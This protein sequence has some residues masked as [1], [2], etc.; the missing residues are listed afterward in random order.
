MPISRRNVISAL[1]ASAIPL[2]LRA[3]AP[4][5]IRDPRI[6]SLAI[7]CRC[8][9]A[10]I[11]PGPAAA[12]IPPEVIRLIQAGTLENRGRVEYT[13]SSR[14]FRIYQTF[15][16]PQAPFPSPSSPRIADNSVAVALDLAIEQMHWSEWKAPDTGKPFLG[17]TASGRTINVMKGPAN[18]D[19]YGVVQFA[20]ERD[21]PHNLSMVSLSYTGAFVAWATEVRGSVKLASSRAA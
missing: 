2:A 20:F 4:A 17:V 7:E 16:K 9:L 18:L 11:L 1:G 21:P 6:E 14:A 5:S 13:P 10:S 3:Q 12:S 15:V 8:P 19:E